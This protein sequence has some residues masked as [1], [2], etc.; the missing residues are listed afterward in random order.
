MISSKVCTPFFEPDDAA[1]RDVDGDAA[2]A[3][4]DVDDDDVALLGTLEGTTSRPCSWL[5]RVIN[6]KQISYYMIWYDTEYINK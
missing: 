2:A 1:T 4:D 3:R 6:Q 5:I